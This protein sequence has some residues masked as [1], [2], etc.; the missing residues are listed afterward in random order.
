MALAEIRQDGDGGLTVIVPAWHD[1]EIYDLE[2]HEMATLLDECTQDGD[3]EP[4]YNEVAVGV[5]EAITH[6]LKLDPVHNH[7]L[8]GAALEAVSPGP[9][10]DK[11]KQFVV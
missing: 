4:D 10:I 7:A 8:L 11:P 9:G 6:A 1:T 3:S 2:A 5:T